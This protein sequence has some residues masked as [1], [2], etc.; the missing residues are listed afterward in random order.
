MW[1]VMKLPMEDKVLMFFVSLGVVS[2]F[3]MPVNQFPS[4]SA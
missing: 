2:M 1:I 4:S 3:I